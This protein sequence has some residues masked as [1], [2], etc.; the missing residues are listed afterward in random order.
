MT[1]RI[2]YIN[3]MKKSYLILL[4]AA[5][6]AVPASALEVNLTPGSLRS[7][8][9]KIGASS[10]TRLILTGSADSTDL[11]L[12]RQLPGN[13]RT[14]DISGLKVAGLPGS[15]IYRTNINKIMLPT[16]GV[17]IH[18]GALSGTKLMSLTIPASVTS[19]GAYAFAENNELTEVTMPARLLAQPGILRNCPKLSKVTV[20]GTVTAL[21]ARTF[22][23]DRSLTAMLP[24]CSSIGD[25]A[26]RNS[27]ITEADLSGVSAVGEF[28]FAETPVTS[29]TADGNTTFGTGAFYGCRELEDLPAWT[30]EVAPLLAATSQL[31]LTNVINTPVISAAAFANNGASDTLT[32]GANVRKIEKDAFRNNTNL[33]E[34][35]VT[36]LAGN[37]PEL[38]HD[39]FSG[40]ENSEGNYDILLSV[41]KDYK[42]AWK[43]HPEWS[44]FKLNAT[45]GADALADAGISISRQG[46]TVTAVC[47]EP[48][49]RFTVFST[50][51]IVLHDSAPHATQAAFTLGTDAVIVVRVVAAGKIKATTLR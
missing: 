4:A 11:V 16:C 13:Y 25:G 48:I 19:V 29:V 31:R 6:L 42:D 45:T 28:A 30:M 1:I 47:A 9:L 3:K 22:E 44:R 32:L 20:D 43:E 39:A 23:N 27:G 33:H 41:D 18:D 24:G 14:L 15:M 36:A 21:P 50:D 37:T 51:G 38:D 46:R 12:L 34:V 40:L 26:Y 2:R 8:L 10:D 49:E 5:A 17:A 7:D 35:R